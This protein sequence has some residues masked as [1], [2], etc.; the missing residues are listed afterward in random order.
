[1]KVFVIDDEQVI[2]NSCHLVLVAEGFEACLFNSADKALQ[3]LQHAV[4]ALII[5]DIKMPGHDGFYFMKEVRKMHGPIPVIAMSGYPT[6]EI[7]ADSDA[8]G[9]TLFL[10]KPFTPDELLDT[11][12]KA[13]GKEKNN[14]K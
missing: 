7:I 2:L 9:A 14:E 5:V 10:E 1:M 6:P 13:L 8:G 12:Y 4:P 3:I 11:I